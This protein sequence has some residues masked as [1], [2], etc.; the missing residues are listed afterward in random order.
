MWF[1]ILK[2]CQNCLKNASVGCFA[3]PKINIFTKQMHTMNLSQNQCDI[4][5]I[6]HHLMTDT[7]GIC[8]TCWVVWHPV[9]QLYINNNTLCHQ[10]VI[11]ACEDVSASWDPQSIFHCS[12][13]TSV[14]LSCPFLLPS[15]RLKRSEESGGIHLRKSFWIWNNALF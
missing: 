2:K 3:E 7:G 1:L 11:N 6:Y 9:W 13:T 5:L 12:G 8:D 14:L 15:F 4:Y 10:H